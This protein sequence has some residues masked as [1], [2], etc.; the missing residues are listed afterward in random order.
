MERDQLIS[1]IRWTGCAEERGGFVFL[2]DPVWSTTQRAVFESLRSK[3][4]NRKLK[5]PQGW[6]CVPTGGTSG[7][8]RCA[9]HDE[10]TLGAAVRGFCRHSGLDRVNAVDVL[11]PHHVSGLMS[12]VRCIATAGSHVAWSWKQLERSEE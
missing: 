10:H 5:I 11:P 3:I 1:L 4:E 9:R 6:L 2:G 8:L 7:G 12:R